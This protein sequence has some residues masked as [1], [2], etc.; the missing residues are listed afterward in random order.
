MKE[1]KKKKQTPQKSLLL[2]SLFSLPSLLLSVSENTSASWGK[3]RYYCNWPKWAARPI[4]QVSAPPRTLFCFIQGPD[5]RKDLYIHSEVISSKLTDSEKSTCFSGLAVAFQGKRT[6]ERDV[7]RAAAHLHVTQM[8]RCFNQSL[9]LL[10]TNISRKWTLKW[11][12]V[13]WVIFFSCV[14]I[15][16]F[17][18]SEYLRCRITCSSPAPVWENN[19]VLIGNQLPL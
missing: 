8:A 2:S 9:K 13:C 5:A 3:T 15:I 10:I 6:E 11:C 16:I 14:I 12:M 1:K 19:R 4:S 17:Y 7:A 18:L